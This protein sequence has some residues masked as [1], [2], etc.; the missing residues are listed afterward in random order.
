MTAMPT[1]QLVVAPVYGMV[2]PTAVWAEVVVNA[3]GAVTA[4]MNEFAGMLVP[5]TGSPTT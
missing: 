5:V 1:A 3:V 4:V 2:V